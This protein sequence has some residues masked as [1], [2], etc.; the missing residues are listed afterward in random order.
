MGRKEDINKYS[1]IYRFIKHIGIFKKR[2]L[3]LLT[4][5]KMFEIMYRQTFNIGST[6]MK[7]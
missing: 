2:D 7:H 6:K 1:N 5:F 3:L 4:L